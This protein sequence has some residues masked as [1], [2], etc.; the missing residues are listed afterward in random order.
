MARFRSSE[1]VSEM[2]RIREIERRAS[3]GRKRKPVVYVIDNYTTIIDEY[4]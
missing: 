1:E 3:G 4:V 2:G